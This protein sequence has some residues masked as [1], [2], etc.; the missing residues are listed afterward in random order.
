M[1]VRQAWKWSKPPYVEL[2]FRSSRLISNPV[3]EGKEAEK[4][5]KAMLNQTRT[6]KLVYTLFICLGAGVPFAQYA[7]DPAPVSLATAVA[8]SLILSFAY[9]V[10]YSLLILPSFSDSGAYSLLSTLPLQKRDYARITM[11]S[12]LRT[13]DYLAVGSIIV[14]V[15]SV[16]VLTLSPL[17]SLFML[18]SVVMND[19]LAVFTGLWLARL[20]YRSISRGGRSRGATVSRTVLIIAWGVA[21]MSVG[22]A[23][24]A[25]VTFL[26]YINQVLSGNFSLALGVL[27]ALL[28][29][30]TFGLVIS[31]L[32]TNGFLGLGGFGAAAPMFTAISYGAGI[33]YTLIAFAAATKTFHMISD[34]SH[35]QGVAIRRETAREF[36]VKLRK[37]VSSYMLKD[38]RIAVKNPSTA[39]ILAFPVFGVIVIIVS[40]GGIAVLSEIDIVM[41]TMMMS[42]FSL[43]AGHLLLEA[44][45]RGLDYTLSLPLGRRLVVTSKSIITTLL[46]LPVPF[47]LLLMQLAHSGALDFA[48]FVPFV[49]IPALSAAVTSEIA[50]MV[51]GRR[52]PSASRTGETKVRRRELHGAVPLQLSGFSIVSGA[53]LGRLLTAIILAIL[54]LALPVTFYLIALS[55]LSS[56]AISLGLML[57]VALLEL[58]AVQLLLRLRS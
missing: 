3:S 45:R 58:A 53:N 37:P 41:M 52:S 56:G 32:S 5:L 33:A 10:I 29:P 26:P 44:E 36:T 28:H 15:G 2:V 21:V 31:S 22:F 50:V 9:L 8:L 42:V 6:S 46:F 16:A 1:T 49:E 55:T 35:G 11:L 17:A 25:V 51:T 43:V 40:F 20:F 54:L 47:V 24:N 23:F 48:S 13:F 12:F 4:R 38:M 7:V 27:V 57:V 39:L 34:I 18:C 30:F 14:T 19:I